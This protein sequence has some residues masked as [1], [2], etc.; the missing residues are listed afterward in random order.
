[1]EMAGSIRLQGPVGHGF[2]LNDL[3]KGCS[4]EMREWAVWESWM[5][6]GSISMSKRRRR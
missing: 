3:H 6:E 5:F 4:Q 1:M 2:C